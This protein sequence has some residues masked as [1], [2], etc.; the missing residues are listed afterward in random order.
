LVIVGKKIFAVSIGVVSTSIFVRVVVNRGCQ[1]GAIGTTYG[2]AE[3][4]IIIAVVYLGRVK[5]VLQE[6]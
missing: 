2:Y 1:R 3:A 4:G 5:C 6:C